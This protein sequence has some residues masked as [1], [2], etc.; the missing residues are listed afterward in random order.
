MPLCF[1]LIGR[2]GPSVR[3][4]CLQL[5]HAVALEILSHR[6]VE[7]RDRAVMGACLVQR[8]S[9]LIA[10]LCVEVV[11]P[12]TKGRRRLL[13]RARLAVRALEPRVA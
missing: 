13:Q 10:S 1:L 3:L 11:A 7:P 6:R 8:D 9:L 2:R 5:Q 12:P 4:E